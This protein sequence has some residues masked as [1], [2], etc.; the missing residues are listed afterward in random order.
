VR[1]AELAEEHEEGG[2]AQEIAESLDAL[3]ALDFGPA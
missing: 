1:S 3:Q 2:T